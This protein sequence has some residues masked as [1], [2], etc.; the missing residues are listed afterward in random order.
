MLPRDRGHP[1]ANA[2]VRISIDTSK[3][4]VAAAA[5][6]AGA[7]YVNDVTALRGDPEMAALVAERGADVCLM[8][9]LGTPAHDAGRAALRRRRR[10]REGL[11]RTSGSRPRSRPGSRASASSST[12]ASA[13]RKT[14]DAQ[15]RAARPPATSSPTLGRP[16]VLGTRASRSSGGSPAARP[17]SGCPRTLATVVMGLRAG[18][19]VFRV[20]DVAPARDALAVAA[21][22]LARDGP[23]RRRG[24]R[25]RRRPDRRRGVRRAPRSASRSR[26]SGSRS[27]PTTASRAAEREIGQR[28]VLDV[29][30]DVGEPDALVTDRVEDTVD[31]GEVCQ[32]IALIAQQR[33]YKTLERLCAVIAD[34]LASQFGAESVDRQGLQARAADPAAGRGG[35]RRGLARGALSRP[36]S[37]VSRHYPGRHGTRSRH[38]ASPPRS[39]A[40]RSSRY[41]HRHF[42]LGGLQRHLDRGDR[43]RR[44]HL[45]AVPLP[46]VPDQARAVPRLPRRLGRA[47]PRDVPRARRRPCRSE[48]ALE[49]MGT[50]Y[51]EPARRPHRAALPD[52]ELRRLLPIP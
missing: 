47:H 49:A 45:P 10:R 34:R 5:L 7:D 38:A 19:E 27:T 50:A 9:M 25:G 15:P 17:P 6:D 29:R 46:A 4:A 26:S 51:V 8:H 20:H 21:A 37:Q 31:Y 52:A 16:I 18:R 48:E 39:G 12:R 11:P 1:R 43:A 24:L 2:G 36:C 35:L 41:A 14:L 33:S 3:A 40:R 13:S 30:F 23:R 32:V 42:A 44:R 28:L 22:T